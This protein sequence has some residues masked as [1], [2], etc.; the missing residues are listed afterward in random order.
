[1]NQQVKKN[2]HK[3]LLRKVVG[4][5]A[6]WTVILKQKKKKKKTRFYKIK[7]MN[8]LLPNVK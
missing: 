3:I 5:S 7:F 8:T 4:L 2:V 6:F 1:M